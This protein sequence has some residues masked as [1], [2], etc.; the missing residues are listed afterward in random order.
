M[1]EEG[2]N[3]LLFPF[4][5]L[6]R[7][8]LGLASFTVLCVIWPI[9]LYRYFVSILAPVCRSDLGLMLSP[10]SRFYG[11]A[12]NSKFNLNIQFT[13]SGK[14]DVPPLVNQV[15]E[16]C[17]LL[18][19]KSTGKFVFPEFQQHL[20]DW[21]GYAFWKNEE[22]FQINQ[23][24]RHLALKNVEDVETNFSISKAIMGAADS[25]VY[26]FQ[27]SAED[28]ASCGLRL[29]RGINFLINYVRTLHKIVQPVSAPWVSTGL[30]PINYSTFTD[31]IPF[32]I[33]K[34][35]SQKF[36]VSV[37]TL[38][39]SIVSGAIR[40]K[41][42]KDGIREPPSGI[43]GLTHVPLPRHSTNLTNQL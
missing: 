31:P 39:I 29:L 24:V 41:F 25:E 3:V 17:I 11:P 12:T 4:V 15:I 23:H 19:N 38:I 20:F 42:L 6:F 7:V 27:P 9:Y 1:Q 32:S 21:L 36:R 5:A 13:L 33:I 10:R 28:C 2:R 35:L 26:Q 30:K 34:D 43:K 37:S 16:R 14:L 18:K 40:R 22:S 8:F